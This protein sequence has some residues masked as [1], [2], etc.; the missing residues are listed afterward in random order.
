MFQLHAP[1]KLSE[2]YKY[3]LQSCVSVTVFMAYS[4]QNCV[5][6][7]VFMAP[8]KLSE[9]ETISLE[10]SVKDYSAHFML[11]FQV[12]KPKLATL[13]F[14]IAWFQCAGWNK[15]KQSVTCKCKTYCF[16]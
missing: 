15:I 14:Y 5:S 11:S 13:K 8:F 6:V 12:Y 10:V 1:F 16:K 2:N 4:L 3:S 7:T 9:N